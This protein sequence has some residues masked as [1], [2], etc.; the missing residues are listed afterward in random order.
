MPLLY[1]CEIVNE[2]TQTL[3]EILK[4]ANL[5][6][7]GTYIEVFLFKCYEFNSI[8]NLSLVLLWNYIYKSKFDIERY[9]A[10][11]FEYYL[12]RNINQLALL[13]PNLKLGSQTVLNVLESRRNKA[14]NRQ[15]IYD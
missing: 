6:K 13:S 8:E 14:M 3:I 15:S 10:I 12:M 9:S 1:S 4:R 7:N 5:L 11:K 2:L